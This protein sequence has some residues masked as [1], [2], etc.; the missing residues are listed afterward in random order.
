M[1]LISLLLCMVI[2]T[3]I[4]NATGSFDSSLFWILFLSVFASCAII[5]AILSLP[6][7]K[8]A[9]GERKVAKR[10]KRL[11]KKYGGYL[12]NDVTIPGENDKTSQIDHIY[13]SEYGIFVVETKNY[14]GRVYGT[15]SQQNWTQVLAYGRT[16]N[17]LYNPVK[18][19]Q[20]HVYRLKEVLGDDF[21][22]VFRS[23][24]VFVKGN[25]DYIES[26]N[27]VDLFYLRRIIK[28]DDKKVMSSVEVDNAYSIIMDY[29]NNPIKTK[30]EH[31]KEI[32]STLKDINENICPRCGGKLVLR[33][34]KNGSFY[35][36]SN[37]PK[38]NFIKRS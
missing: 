9:F 10:L 13:I 19:N 12:I 30:K 18:Q 33:K 16:K 4:A 25:I 20:T 36:C 26:E 6:S 21:K 5:A 24:V 37:Y 28:K 3:P 7:V 22:Y 34:G 23:V 2:A 29:K 31:I 27:V 8:G 15:D 38:C 14:S 32:K 35:G 17:Q 11:V 1:A